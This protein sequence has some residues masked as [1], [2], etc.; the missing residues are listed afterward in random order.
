M[1][2]YI[3]I[4]LPALLMA[5]AAGSCSHE[6]D[7]FDGPSLVDRFG[8]FNLL[9]P[10]AVSRQ[11]V[12]FSAGETVAFT[13][14]FNKRVEWMVRITGMESGAVK[15]IEGFENE[16][17]AE[18]ATWSGGT[19][20]L[21]LFKE[22][23]CMVELIIPEEPSFNQAAE[24]EVVGAK[25]YEG[26]VAADFEEAPGSNI[27]VGNF[28]FELAP[29]SGRSM[30]APAAQGDWFY[31]LRGTDNVVPNFFAG[32][33]DIKAS[34]TGETYFPVPATVPEEL[35]FNMF[36]YSDGSPYTIAVIQLIFDSNDSGTFEDGQD[37][38]FPYGDIPVNWEGW[39]HFHKP[40]S[41]LGISEAQ[42]QKIVAI[43]AVLISDMNAQPNPPQQVDFGIDFLV[44]TAG[45]PLVL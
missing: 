39:R 26:E 14:R 40:V 36:L 45:K 34:I 9:E 30:E 7:V 8:E 41:E 16:L 18:N 20:E 5:L 15:I 12:D 17:N 25:I 31:L 38:V 13:A 27:F 35:F 42:L 32:L 10:L 22:E 37:Q 19:T 6:T 4:Y 23:N 11:A 24:V 29:Q 3:L 44:F 33:I 2:K 43:R 1:K 21:P 28:E